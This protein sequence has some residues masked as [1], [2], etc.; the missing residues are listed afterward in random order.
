[1]A[2]CIHAVEHYEGVFQ[3]SLLLYDSKKGFNHLPFGI[4]FTPEQLQKRILTI[5]RDMEGVVCLID[6]SLARTSRNMMT[7][8]MQS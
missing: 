5:L 7:V 3:S 6:W 4:S 8:C 2:M 1:M